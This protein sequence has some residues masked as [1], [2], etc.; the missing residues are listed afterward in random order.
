MRLVLLLVTAYLSATNA[1]TGPGMKITLYERG[2]QYLATVAM[3]S[4]QKQIEHLQIPDRAG[5]KQLPV[6]H[7]TYNISNIK[8]EKFIP[9][10]ASVSIEPLKWSLAE[11]TSVLT[12]D[13]SYEYR[14]GLLPVRDRGSVE[15]TLSVNLDTII[16]LDQ[17]DTG[18][19]RVKTRDCRSDVTKVQV[20]F[21]GGESW[22]YNLF[23]EKIEAHIREMFHERICQGVRIVIDEKTEVS[24]ANISVI[25]DLHDKVILDYRLVS[26]PVLSGQYIDLPVK[27]EYYWKTD[28]KE[29]PVSP[30]RFPANHS[31]SS[32]VG[33]WISEYSLNSLGY[34]IYKHAPLTHDFTQ[35]ELPP[36]K[37]FM[38]ET[39]CRSSEQ[40]CIGYLVPKIHELYPDSVVFLE[41]TAIKA[42]MMQ[43]TSQGIQSDWL[44]LIQYHVQSNFSTHFLFSTYVKVSF[45]LE[46]YV[47]DKAIKVKFAYFTR[48]MELDESAIGDIDLGRLTPLLDTVIDEYFIPELQQYTNEGIALPNIKDVYYRK[49][50]LKFQEGTFYVGVDMEYVEAASW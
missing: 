15:F 25:L 44:G 26:D 24:L 9:P 23:D 5:T 1:Y 33:F 11:S 39:T 16:N 49:P 28:R 38:L 31:D 2:Y 43:F 46:P 21:Y 12:A 30:N 8:I 13:W 27:G 47:E 41:M 10:R 29:Y 50:V 42:P 6:G 34:A 4:L 37:Q 20:H 14:I 3:R 17:D 19:P 7:V 48:Q 35:A 32:M 40:S 22:I 36:K 18:R 45:K